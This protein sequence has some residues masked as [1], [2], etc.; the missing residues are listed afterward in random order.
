MKQS[1]C[2]GSEWLY[3]KIY[4]G[5]KTADFILTEKLNP[6][7]LFLLEKKIIDKWFFIR[8]KD[9]DEHIR[10]R[11]NCKSIDNISLVI[12]HLYPIFNE[13][14]ESDLIWKL[15]SD[16]YQREIERYGKT[17]ILDSENIFYYDSKM[18]LDYISIKQYFE[19]DET[20]L[21]FSF[22]AIDSFLDSFSLTIKDKLSLL[23]YLQLSFKK[24]FETEKLIKKE[25]DKHYRKLFS[26]IIYFLDYKAVEEY[27]EIFNIILQKQINIEPL[28]NTIKSKIQISLNS[29]LSSH[30]HMMINRQFTSKQRNYECLIYD[31]L[32]RYYKNVFFKKENT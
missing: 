17:T 27:P 29:F 13:L 12:N 16:T 23:D 26:E 2:L 1:F 19:K 10:L 15:Q 20:Q 11:F 24:E 30:I 22:L 18:M 14:M 7:I 21:L 25:F 32:Y 6:I 3:Y 28:V 9:P 4:T 31:H 5:L 8:Y